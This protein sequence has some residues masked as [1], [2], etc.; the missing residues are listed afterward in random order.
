MDRIRIC[1]YH[2][3]GL[4]SSTNNIYDICQNNDIVVLQE[5]WL[6]KDE[7]CILTNIHNEFNGVGLSP[8]NTEENIIKG[9][10]YG[11]VAVL[12]RKSLDKIAKIIL[13]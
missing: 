13:S 7:I 1:S 6:F 12:W 4:K 11:D 3:E 9:R 5:H 8:V 2:C 10:P